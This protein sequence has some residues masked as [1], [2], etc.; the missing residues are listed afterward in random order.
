MTMDTTDVV[1]VA[2]STGNSSSYLDWSPIIGG[3][4]VAAAITTIMA[5]FGSAIGLSMVSADTSR[6]SGLTALAIAGGIWALWVTISACAAGG[7]LAGR[8]R[9]PTLDATDHERHVRDGAHGLVVWAA[10]AL[11]VAM[12]TSSVLTGAAK[13]AA[14]GVT[15]AATGAGALISQ[16]A[17]PLGSALD[18]V[19]RSTGSE[20]VSAGER[21]EASRI[22]SRSLAS[23]ALDPADRTYIANRLAARANISQPDAE[24]RIDDAYAKLN[25]AKETAKQAAERARRMG[26]ITAFLTAAALLAGAAAAWFAAV[27]GGKHRD[28][29]IDLTALF[30]SR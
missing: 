10:G 26:V 28:E 3:A 5:A 1:V 17:D 13:T 2:P 21:E 24:K 8:M 15:A 23:G 11:L 22:L 14:T 19:M 4:V 9:R 12:L 27:L 7:Y 29:E 20:P 16:Q 6:S 30:G 18:S 25:Q